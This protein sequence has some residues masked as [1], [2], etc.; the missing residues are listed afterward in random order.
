MEIEQNSASTKDNIYT[1]Q[2]QHHNDHSFYIQT[3]ARRLP[4]RGTTYYPPLWIWR[5]LLFLDRKKTAQHYG[6][7][8]NT[9]KTFPTSERRYWNC[10]TKR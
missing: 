1:D 6:Y 3:T 7:S 4:R 5:F 9:D 2:I 10:M 8:S